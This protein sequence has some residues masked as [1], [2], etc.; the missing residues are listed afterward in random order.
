MRHSVADVPSP[1]TASTLVASASAGHG[2][3]FWLAVPAAAGLLTCGWICLLMRAVN[4]LCADAGDPAWRV[5]FLAARVSGAPVRRRDA[6]RFAL[7]RSVR[8][9]AW[10]P[11]KLSV[12]EWTALGS[13]LGGTLGLLFFLAARGGTV[14]EGAIVTMNTSRTDNRM[15]SFRARAARYAVLWA[16]TAVVGTVVAAL[17]ATGGG[18]H[19]VVAALAVVIAACL[20]LPVF[21]LGPEIRNQRRAARG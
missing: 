5:A 9:G 14:E 4:A 15:T 11:E 7:W 1:G 17:T 12:G 10:P 6:V 2:I 13:L 21:L 18:E 8:A 3:E 16:L 19:A 20:A